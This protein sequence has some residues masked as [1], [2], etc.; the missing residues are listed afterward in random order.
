MEGEEIETVCIYNTFENLCCKGK[1]RNETSW[2]KNRVKGSLRKDTVEWERLEIKPKEK[3]SSVYKY[4]KEGGDEIQ[5]QAEE[6][7]LNGWRDLHIRRLKLVL[8]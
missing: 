7:T 1:Q 3:D 5:S 4:S 2:R 6:V 8:Q